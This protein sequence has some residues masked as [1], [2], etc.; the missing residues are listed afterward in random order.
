MEN[1]K[2]EKTVKNEKTT[3]TETIFKKRSEMTKEDLKQLNFYPVIFREYKNGS[4]TFIVEVVKDK[5]R[6]N[7]SSTDRITFDFNT[8]NLIKLFY[9]KDSSFAVNLPIRFVKGIGKTGKVYYLYE[10]Y[11][12]ANM[13]Y[14]G[15]ISPNT[16]KLLETLVSMNY[17]DPINFVELTVND[18]EN[19]IDGKSVLDLFN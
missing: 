17:I 15:F 14:S 8:W 6:L 18:E 9:K 13:V 11:V 4:A 2:N 10:L 19:S 5:L 7:D 1:L 16:I 12:A 3:N